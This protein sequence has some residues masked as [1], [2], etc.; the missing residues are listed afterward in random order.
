M[1]TFFAFIIVFGILVFVH[2]LGHF[3]M[4][5]KFGVR[6]EEFGFGFPPRLWSKKKRDTLYSV[7]L[8]P[9]GGFVRLFG[10]QGEN[11]N[12]HESY[13]SKSKLQKILILVSGVSMNFL[14]AVFLLT[15]AYG[16]GMET[17]IPGMENHKGVVNEQKITIVEVE[18]D[19]P[20]SAVLQ[21][22]DVITEVEGHKISVSEEVFMRINEALKEDAEKPVRLAVLRDGK[23]FNEELKTYE[24]EIDIKNEKRKIRRIGVGL[25]TVGKLRAPLYL[26]PIVALSETIRLTQLTFVGILFFFG[27]IISSLTISEG[28]VGPAEIVALTGGF[29]RAGLMPLIQFMAM[30]SVS[31]A[32]IN[33]MPIPALDGGH[34]LIL[35]VEKIR[36]RDLSHDAKNMVQFV[37]FGMLLLLMIVI[38]IRD[39]TG[40]S[41]LE[42]IKKLF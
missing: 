10:E 31:L 37:G 12:N 41:V 9:L 42:Y 25:E 40:I 14:L 27:S 32:V 34:V 11:E 29:A 16:V 18:K 26:A 39:L 4:A 15:I 2:E 22:G 1:L 6:V 36:R 13:A 7:N 3:L 8:I 21:V 5:R 28:V 38:T 30:L 35:I 19:T 33:I 23:T 17:K 24:A 20:A